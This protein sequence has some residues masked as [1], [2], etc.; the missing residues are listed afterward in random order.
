[1]TQDKWNNERTNLKIAFANGEIVNASRQDLERYLV[2]LANTP[3]FPGAINDISQG[4]PAHKRDTE[5]YAAIIRHLLT[6]RL[7][8]ELLGKSHEIAKESNIIARE[9]KEISRH[10]E[11]VARVSAAGAI[12][13]AALTGLA[14]YLEHRSTPPSKIYGTPL[15]PPQPL[16]SNQQPT[17]SMNTLFPANNYASNAHLTIPPPA[18]NSAAASQATPVTK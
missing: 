15:P 12:V 8:Q 11:F 1:M 2:V 9:S 6:I 13:L 4:Q 16:S 3:M 17:S 7:G 10:A 5:T 14:I 18:T